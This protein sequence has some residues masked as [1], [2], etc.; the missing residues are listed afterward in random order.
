MAEVVV[1][2]VPHLTSTILEVNALL[3]AG[4]RCELDEV[5]EKAKDGS[6]FDWLRLKGVETLQFTSNERTELLTLFTSLDAEV[7]ERR[8]FGIEH[9]GYALVVAWLV[10]ALQ[11]R[12]ASEGLYPV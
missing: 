12:L 11:Q 6:L 10:E 2:P 8:K 7:H 4:Q 1:T 5:T 3:D 9:N